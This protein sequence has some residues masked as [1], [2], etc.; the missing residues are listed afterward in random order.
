MNPSPKLRMRWKLA[1]YENIAS[2]IVDTLQGTLFGVLPTRTVAQDV[3]PEE[4][5]RLWWAD[6][7]GN[8][9]SI[10]DVLMEAWVPAAVFGHTFLVAEPP[11][12]AE[13]VADRTA[14]LTSLYSPLDVIDWLTD[15]RGMLTAIKCLD[16]APRASLNVAAKP[17]DLRVRVIDAK[18][19]TTYD[20]SGTE[21]EKVEHDYGVLPVAVLYSRKRSLIKVVGKSILGD[22]Q[23][24]LD[25]YNMG[26]E[27]R[28]LLRGQTFAM[29]NVP[30]GQDGDVE[31][32]RTLIGSQSG[33]QSVLFSRNPANLLEPSGTSLEGY[34]REID[35]VVRACYRNA[36]VSW[37]GDSRDAEAADSKRLKRE[38]MR[39]ALTKF[40]KECA[41]SERKLTELVFRAVYGDRWKAELARVQPRTAWPKEFTLP[42]LDAI[43][44]R[45]V[46]AL[47]LDLGATAA[48]QLKKDTAKALLPEATPEQAATIDDE[49][50]AQTI[51]TAEEKQAALV[52]ASAARMAE[53]GQPKAKPEPPKPGQQAA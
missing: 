24:Y 35:R 8:G 33:T 37:E 7:D 44:A 40:A 23:V 29:I 1:R 32:E 10:D 31:S 45:T 52:E 6:A 5:I 11:S 50:D 27:G 17:S 20:A 38:D 48:K 34:H 36:L 15:A 30:I 26:S 18:A 21:I 13:T 16:I 2:T 49:I 12:D 51:L 39:A 3:K 47:T 42:D 19:Y 4:A 28:E 46:E 41:G 43:I 53:A 9:A 25:L 22:P 14:P